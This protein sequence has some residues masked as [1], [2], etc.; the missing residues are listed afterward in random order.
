MSYKKSIQVS[1]TD[2]TKSVYFTSVLKMAQET[3]IEDLQKRFSETYALLKKGKIAFPVVQANANYLLP[4]FVFD[5]ID[6]TVELCFKNTSFIVYSE[7]FK[8]GKTHAK[9]EITHVCVDLQTN[10]KISSK[11]L[12]HEVSTL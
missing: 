1:D 8:D 10:Q 5:D 9:A 3:F 6:I 4:L 11:E 2:F 7:F 12:F